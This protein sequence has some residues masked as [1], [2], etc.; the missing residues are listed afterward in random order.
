MSHVILAFMRSDFFN[1]DETPDE[2][3]LFTT[4]KEVRS[5]FSRDTKVM[6]AIG[7]WGDTKGFE[8]GAESETSRK[9][10]ARQVAAMVDA[11]GADGVDIDWEYPGYVLSDHTVG[12]SLT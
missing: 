12:R 9:R 11:T 5:S 4:V 2:F 7:G 10:W 1:V 3:P 8:E 6:V